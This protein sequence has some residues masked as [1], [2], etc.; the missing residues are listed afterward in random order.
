[1]SLSTNTKIMPH[2]VSTEQV[3]LSC[4]INYPEAYYEAST[5]EDDVFYRAEHKIL[6]MCIKK[7]YVS[8]K[9]V[10]AV[11]IFATLTEEEIEYIGGE[12][13]LNSLVE[14]YGSK[15]SR[16]IEIVK[17]YIQI[18]LEFYNRRNLIVNSQKLIEECY[19]NN[20]QEI[21]TILSSYLPNFALSNHTNDKIYY[22]EDFIEMIQEYQ[23]KE[24]NYIP[25][26]DSSLDTILNGGLGE[27]EL[28]ILAGKSGMGKTAVAINLFTSLIKTN[29]AIYFSLE[30]TFNEIAKRIYSN[31]T[32]KHLHNDLT[33][34]DLD[35]LYLAIGTRKNMA[36]V[37]NTKFN[38]TLLRKYI[39][40]YKLK[41][42]ELNVVIIDYLQIMSRKNK[43]SEYEALTEITREL[44]IIAMEF[45]ICI[46]CLSQLSRAGADR[47]EKRPQLSDLRGS[48]SIEQD[49]DIVMFIHRE[50]WYYKELG[51]SVPLEL[52]N[53]LELIIAKFRR[54]MP[55]KILY[56]ADLKYSY[57]DVMPPLLKSK[58][59]DFLK[60]KNN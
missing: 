3:L 30:M 28:I 58:Y 52:Q 42:G 13:Y 7:L 37:D 46:V 24:E 55:N 23:G 48:G 10:N 12:D 38:L 17:S 5:L 43:Q 18:L 56:Q 59:I 20:E 50:E 60:P 9:E 51:Q 35:N 21:E 14:C 40:D 15:C 32:H 53:G 29:N 11:T 41:Y 8:K 1:M 54:Y 27:G 16:F 6:F 47:K 4:I 44:K 57:L 33:N 45:K 36:I 19:S 49:A 2:D 22:T 34:E 31:I 39:I 26:N 25:T